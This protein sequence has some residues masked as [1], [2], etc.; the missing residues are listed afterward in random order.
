MPNISSAKM[1]T[2]SASSVYKTAS[3]YVLGAGYQNG[4]LLSTEIPALHRFVNT[5]SAFQYNHKHSLVVRLTY[6]ARLRPANLGL[7]TLREVVESWKFWSVCLGIPST[8]DSL[9]KDCTPEQ[10][11]SRFSIGRA[12]IG[13]KTVIQPLHRSTPGSADELVS[14]P[15]SHAHWPSMSR[16]QAVNVDLCLICKLLGIKFT[17]DRG[18]A[19]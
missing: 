15:T 17:W 5:M 4:F 10:T 11:S 13:A 3:V 2:I 7:A 1:L 8:M 18:T 12:L 14:A 9:V 6:A 16:P 19:R